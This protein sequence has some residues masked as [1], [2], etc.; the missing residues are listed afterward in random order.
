[1]ILKQYL[2]PSIE[3]VSLQDMKEHLR[4]DA[5]SFDSNLTL[6][7]SLAYGSKAVQNNY[8]VHVGTGVDVLGKS[9]EVLLHCGTNGA[10]GTNDT[11]IE[12]SD[13][14]ATGYT[15]WTG[16]AFTQVTTA[17]DNADF[18]LAYTGSKSYIRTASKVLLA[19]CEFGTS[20]ATYSSDTTED[21]ILTAIITAARQQVEAILQRQLITAT[22]DALLDEFPDKNFIPLPFGSLQSVTSITYWEAG[23]AAPEPPMTVTTD[24]LVDISSDPGRIV[25]PYGVS[26]P[27]FTAHPVNPIAIRFVCGYGATTASV[28]AAIRTAIKMLAEDYWNN[29]SA[30]HTQAAGN[31][32][33]NKAVLNLLMPFRLWRF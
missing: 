29:R 23:V 2:A 8:T 16:G 24:Y 32:T 4:L 17:N 7:Q 14:L 30:T 25:L 9:A 18:K 10:T 12:E 22:W 21:N 20:I 15:A 3:P 27:S 26:W 31:V 6:A 11:R 13:Q 1:M 28:P 33:E 5:G 19:A